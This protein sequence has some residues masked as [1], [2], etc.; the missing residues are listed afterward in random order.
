[1]S[2]DA[3]LCQGWRAFSGVRQLPDLDI[4]RQFEYQWVV[5]KILHPTSRLLRVFK[6]IYERN[7][8]SRSDLVEK[9][10]H[11]TFLIS[12]MCDDL[13][14]AEL[15]RETGP[16]SSTGGRPPTLLSVNPDLG[17]LVGLHVGTVNVR[18]AVTDMTGQT[19]AYQKAPSRAE[20]G[21]GEAIPHLVSLVE[22]TMARGGADTTRLR[23][24]GIGISGVLDRESG[25]TLFWPKVP[26]WVNVPVKQMFADRF[27]TFVEVE[28]T[29]RTMALAER[30]FGAGA[31]AGEF[32]YVMVGAGAG[33][34]LFLN[35]TLYT[36]AHGFAGEFGHLSVDVNGPL[37]SCGN[38]GCIETYVSASALIRTARQAI[39]QGLAIQLWQLCG[40]DPER[41]S[42]ESIAQAAVL[43][44]RF[45]SNLLSEAGARLGAGIVGLVNMLNPELIILGGGLAAAAGNFLI[46]AVERVVRE[47]ALS[48]PAV[49]TRIQLSTLE[50][51]DW[52]RGGALLVADNALEQALRE[53]LPS[54]DGDVTD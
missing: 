48:R 46:P 7:Q 52:A 2:P 17:V 33:A 18:I 54:A 15:V 13:Q 10:G 30:R 16:G 20:A 24:I 6:L 34:A 21:P 22:E 14:R 5:P 49:Q 37:C 11:S 51:T 43:E 31:E 28:D 23:G 32:I 50:E 4:H 19:L 42:I 44:D 9:T 39:G 53:A 12:K 3:R 26:Q 29:P 25:T 27:G 36:G 8:I 41:V 40:G 45:S 1:L 47:R 35:G 38:R